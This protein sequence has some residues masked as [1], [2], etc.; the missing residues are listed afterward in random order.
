MKK[1]TKLILLFL[2]CSLMLSVFVSCKANKAT[3]K[4]T[5]EKTE[6]QNLYDADGYLNDSLPDNLDYGKEEI[7]ILGWN[8][9]RSEF[10]DADQGLK[11]SDE[12]LSTVLQR[13]WELQDYLGVELTYHVEVGDADHTSEWVQTVRTSSMSGL[14]YDILAGHTST[15][16]SVVLNGLA[17]DL[18]DDQSLPYLDFE[19]TWW[20]H[21]LIENCSLNGRFFMITGDSTPTYTSFVYCIYFNEAMVE[22]YGLTSPYDMVKNNQWTVENM[23]VMTKDVYQDLDSSENL[24]Q[25]DIIPLLGANYDFPALVYGAGIP[26]IET[27]TEGR[28]VYSDLFTGEKMLNVMG[29]FQM[30][31]TLMNWGIGN[32]LPR[33]KMFKDSQCLFLITESGTAASSF[34][35]VEFAY[36][37]VPCPKY[38]S[39]QTEYI[40]SARQPIT[41]YAIA[42]HTDSDRLEMIS[43][44][45]ER[46]A[47]GG[48]RTITPLVFDSIMKFRRSTSPEMAEMLELVRSTTYFDVGRVYS[49]AL[50]YIS[51]KPT[52]ALAL[53]SSWSTFMKQNSERFNT[54]LD[55]LIESMSK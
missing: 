44:T 52:S 32:T 55:N 51:D 11:D 49:A 50:E 10:Y 26:I 35:D 30:Y 19:K 5:E 43:A 40:S 20:N 48:Y 8:S 23:A 31:S 18:S 17:Y 7:K 41:M 15:M 28:W 24:S 38:D 9:Q 27:N 16:G 34:S 21:A 54:A 4:E 33:L 12:I 39:A 36:G 29:N 1:L 14:S 53:G 45:L 47:S 37:C 2:V 25:G 46:M 6:D 13:D 22:S 3:P 42:L